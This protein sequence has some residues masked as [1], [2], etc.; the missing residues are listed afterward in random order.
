MSTKL[1]RTLFALAA[2][3][4]LAASGGAI[5]A[6]GGGGASDLAKPKPIPYEINDLFIETNATD[7]DI[8]LQLLAD[9][10][11]WDKFTLR[12]PKG[13]KV[14]MQARTEGRLAGWGLTELFWETAEPEFSEVP[15]SK[16]QKRFPAGKYTF[17]GRTVDGRKIVGSDQLTHVIPEGPVVTSPT[18]GEEANANS[19]TVSW[20]PVTKPDGVD[21]VSYQVIV[22]QEPVERVT[23]NLNADVTSVDIPAE[24]LTPGAPETKVEVLAREKS[25]NQTI[26]EVPFSVK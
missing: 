16:F 2:I 20:E 19:L 21:I 22:L 3:G 10:D 7:G 17:R 4:A 26:T 9:V 1:K 14:M 18:K 8:G 23:L 6:T 11:E 24:A 25:G 5:A 15:L 12:D 13:R